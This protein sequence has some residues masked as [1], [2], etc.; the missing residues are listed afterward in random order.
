M[1]DGYKILYRGPIGRCEAVT[2]TITP[3]S[4]PPPSLL[5]KLNRLES[6][7]IVLFST[8]SEQKKLKLI[9][10]VVFPTKD[11][12]ER[13]ISYIFL[14]EGISNDRTETCPTCLLMLLIRFSVLFNWSYFVPLL[15]LLISISSISEFSHL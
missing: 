15:M 11:F 9:F 2:L 4:Q 3:T 14:P 6:A 12:H 7:E 1:S 13:Q 5:S 8:K 10:S